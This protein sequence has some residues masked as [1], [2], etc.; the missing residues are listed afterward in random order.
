MVEQAIPESD[1]VE[2]FYQDSKTMCTYPNKG[3]DFYETFL[4][5]AGSFYE[6][7]KASDLESHGF[8][9]RQLSLRSEAIAM[10]SINKRSQ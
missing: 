4:K 1:L 2:R 5:Q 9:S 3:E 10:K 7:V 6:A 8:S